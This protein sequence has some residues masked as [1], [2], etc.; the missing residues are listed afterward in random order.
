M[1]FAQRSD[2]TAK[3]FK[4]KYFF[5]C[6]DVDG[7]DFCAISQGKG[8]IVGLG[9]TCK[10]KVREKTLARTIDPQNY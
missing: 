2:W 4:Q 5:M 1:V 8:D 10:Q 9:R 3:Q 6:H 7:W